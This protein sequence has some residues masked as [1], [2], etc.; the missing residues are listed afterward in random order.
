[1]PSIVCRVAIDRSEVARRQV[2]S[3]FDTRIK[4][5]TAVRISG[6]SF[7]QATIISANFWPSVRVAV[8]GDGGLAVSV[9]C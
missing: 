7:V 3:S 6:G 1:M 9:T 8:S 5:S 4:V 2:A